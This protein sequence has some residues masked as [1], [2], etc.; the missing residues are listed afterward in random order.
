MPKDVKTTEVSEPSSF[1]TNFEGVYS[2]DWGV[3]VLRSVGG[4]RVRGVYTH[5]A[6]TISGRFVNG[7][8]IGRWCE[9]P[10]RAP[11][12]DAGDVELDFVVS[13]DGVVSM[14]GRWVYGQKSADKSWNEDWDITLTSTTPDD[15]LLARFNDE[16]AFCDKP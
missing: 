6:G 10:S 12:D 16:S 13:A 4:D 1:P 15:A 5:D 14:D 11:E 7:Q 8:F 9:T 2:G 3:M